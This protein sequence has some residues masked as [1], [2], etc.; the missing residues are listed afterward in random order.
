MTDSNEEKPKIEKNLVYCK[1]HPRLGGDA[2][3]FA[4]FLNSVEPDI[5]KQ[6]N[7]MDGER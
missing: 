3:Q 2:D 5:S 7:K 4:Q 6:G 1:I